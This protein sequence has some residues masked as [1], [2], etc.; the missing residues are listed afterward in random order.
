MA[1]HSLVL[2]RWPSSTSEVIEKLEA[3]A[4]LINHSYTRYIAE[5][6]YANLAILASKSYPL[7]DLLSIPGHLIESSAMNWLSQ[8]YERKVACR[9]VPEDDR[10]KSMGFCYFLYSAGT[11]LGLWLTPIAAQ[12]FGWPAALL[13]YTIIGFAWAVRPF[14]PQ[15]LNL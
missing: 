4:G 2:H 10:S 3:I 5:A 8:L 13:V 11:F 9:W 1:R 7:H 6:L 12:P 14:W 15:R